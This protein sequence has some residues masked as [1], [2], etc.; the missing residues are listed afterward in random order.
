MLQGKVDTN[1]AQIAA[2]DLTANDKQSLKLT[3]V[4]EWSK[5]LSATAKIDWLTSP[6]TGSIR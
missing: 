4:L 3:G 6:G 5:G 1:G 2:L